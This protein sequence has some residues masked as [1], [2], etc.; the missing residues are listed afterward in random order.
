M[1]IMHLVLMSLENGPCREGRV[2]GHTPAAPHHFLP[3]V[4]YTQSSLYVIILLFDNA[5]CEHFHQASP[6]RT[7]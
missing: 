4:L 3:S 5:T 1:Q 7:M 6:C 2:T